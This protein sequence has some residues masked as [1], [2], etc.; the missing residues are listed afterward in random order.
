MTIVQIGSM[1][2]PETA[3]WGWLFNGLTGWDSTADNKVGVT[4]RPRG[5]GAFGRGRAYRSSL[6]ISLDLV[7]LGDD[8]VDLRSARLQLAALG[9]EGPELMTVTDELGSFSRM[10]TIEHV[11]VPDHHGRSAQ[12]G[13]SVDMVAEDPRK[14]GL[15]QS[16]STVLPTPGTGLV[17]PLVYPLDW[18]QPG[19][20]GSITLTNFGT[21]AA[22]PV[23]TVE[24]G[25]ASGVTVTESGSGKRLTLARE[26]P[27]GSSV[28]F[29]G[30]TR[31]V[32][33]DGVTDISSTFL[34]R[35][36]WPL[37]DPGHTS[38]F[39]FSGTAAG[40]VPSLTGE[41]QSAWW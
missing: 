15:R 31:R 41:L 14:Y 1:L 29:D 23:F 27:T 20:G 25:L 7:F 8:Q 6:P 16:D 30:R 40:G 2:F 11:D 21:A 34:T 38:T 3:S 35:R 37:I 22:A 17:Y 10:V 24:G 26:I 33:L 19:D 18:G 5:H 13:I 32:L 39:L 12:D 36:E 9:A 28:V 4:E